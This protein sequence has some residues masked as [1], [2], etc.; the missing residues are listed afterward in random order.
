LNIGEKVKGKSPA[1]AAAP[2]LRK[3][4][5]KGQGQERETDE[6]L[7]LPSFLKRVAP[8]GRVFFPP[9]RFA[10]FFFAL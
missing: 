6:P 3:R 4:V 2:S 10:L 9:Q 1:A 5:G 7:F 8:Q